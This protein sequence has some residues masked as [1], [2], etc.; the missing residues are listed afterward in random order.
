MNAISCNNI[1]IG[2]YCIENLI[3]NK[4]YIGQSINIKHRWDYHKSEL[5]NN[6]HKNTHLQNAWNKYGE[7]NFK[8]SIIECCSVDELDEKE[9]YYISLYDTYK[10][11]YNR[12]M[13]GKS[14]RDVTEET[15]KLISDAKSQV[16]VQLTLDGD[17]IKEWKSARDIYIKLGYR[18]EALCG[19]LCGASKSYDGYIWIYKDI[20]NSEN[21]D[22]KKYYRI[23]NSDGKSKQIVQCNLNNECIKIYTPYISYRIFLNNIIRI[24]NIIY[25]YI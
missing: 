11:G 18:Q 15:K 21:F 10:N 5:R 19:N 20:Y 2:I 23:N 22:I 3:N 7:N 12:D 4:K 16:I 24:F 1:I 14:N 8:F 17:F 25:N 9:V 6:Q 13:G